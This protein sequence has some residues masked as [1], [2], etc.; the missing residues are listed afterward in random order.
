MK[1]TKKSENVLIMLKKESKQWKWLKQ[2][3][4]KKTN[5]VKLQKNFKIFIIPNFWNIRIA[6]KSRDQKDMNLDPILLKSRADCAIKEKSWAD[7][8]LCDVV[9][10]LVVIFGTIES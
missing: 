10:L 8:W 1:I 9:H 3:M 2:S 4:K 7:W 6:R 5:Q